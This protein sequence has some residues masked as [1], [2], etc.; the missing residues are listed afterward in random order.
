MG[1]KKMRCESKTLKSIGGQLTPELLMPKD[2]CTWTAWGGR[3]PAH[4][5][6]ATAPSSRNSSCLSSPLLHADDFLHSTMKLFLLVTP[7]VARIQVHWQRRMTR[8]RYVSV[9]WRRSSVVSI[10]CQLWIPIID[11]SPGFVLLVSLVLNGSQ[12]RRVY[13]VA[14]PI[15]FYHTE[16]WLQLLY[17]LLPNSNSNKHHLY[18]HCTLLIWTECHKSNQSA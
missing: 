15:T 6:P 17:A 13:T 3:G 10:V 16:L 1:S 7:P 8:C 5:T 9:F 2:T 11:D 18:Y 4:K 12:T 14:H